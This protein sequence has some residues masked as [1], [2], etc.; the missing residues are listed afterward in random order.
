[1]AVWLD[2]FLPAGLS[3]IS[4]GIIAVPALLAG[5]IH[6]KDVWRYGNWI[7]QAITD[8]C[9]RHHDEDRPMLE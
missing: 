2:I 9:W 5:A 7:P 1:M 6:L 4:E 3:R 8:I